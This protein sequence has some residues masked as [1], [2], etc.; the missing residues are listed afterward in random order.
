MLGHEVDGWTDMPLWIP[1]SANMPGFLSVSIQ[2]ARVAGLNFRPLE[3]T[4]RDTLAWES[5]RNGTEK[6]AGLDPDKER[7][8]LKDWNKKGF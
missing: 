8:V 7:A 4:M 5:A 1:D 6:K 3:K 2:K